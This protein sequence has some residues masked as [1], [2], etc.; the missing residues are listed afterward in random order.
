[1]ADFQI[2]FEAIGTHWVLDCFDVENSKTKDLIEEEI[3]LLI[4]EF[5]KTYSR[6]RND[7]IITK[8]ASKSGIYEF[9]ER[10]IS[11]LE[12]YEKLYKITDGKFTLLIGRVLEQ[13]GYDKNYSLVPQKIDKLP[14]NSEIFTTNKNVLEIKKPFILDFGG[15]GKGYLIDLISEIFKKHK[16]FTF[17]ID[18]GGDILNKTEGTK[19]IR[20]GLENPNNFE[21]VIGVMSVLNQSIC[22]SSGSRRKWG[23]FHHIIDPTTLQ[24][25]ENI[26]STWAIADTTL[27]ADAMATCL[28]LTSPEKLKK[29]FKFE[30][31]ILNS[32]FTI[33]KSDGFNAELFIK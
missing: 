23:K 32:N 1:M 30:Y 18:G 10:D 5:D 27:I 25:P 11:F 22:A 2:K 16:I 31:L 17:T 3:N 28:F 12:L 15:L 33:N 21:E 14:K 13:S 4:E 20:V 8:I 26:L 29:Y 19:P 9:P 7:S 6:F 24:S